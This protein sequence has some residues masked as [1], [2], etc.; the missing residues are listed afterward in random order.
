MGA[1][2]A[3]AGHELC[4][5]YQPSVWTLTLQPRCP[6]AWLDASVARDTKGEYEPAQYVTAV[7]GDISLP[8]VPWA[9]LHCVMGAEQASALA[10]C[11]CC[12]VLAMRAVMGMDTR[13]AAALSHA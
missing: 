3:T 6:R 5:P 10:C 9:A 7:W 12:H 4:R 1:W 2:V 13:A 8:L 11:C